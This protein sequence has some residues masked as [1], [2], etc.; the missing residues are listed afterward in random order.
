MLILCQVNLLN[1]H[2]YVVYDLA[3]SL[4]LVAALAKYVLVTPRGGIYAR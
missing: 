4:F 2:V 3:C 1:Y